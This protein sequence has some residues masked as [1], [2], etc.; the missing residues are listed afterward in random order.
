MPQ[1]GTE[2]VEVTTRPHP[3]HDD[4]SPQKKID[5]F[6]AKGF[7]GSQ[8]R[9]VPAVGAEGGNLSDHEIILVDVTW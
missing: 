4:A 2:S 7:V 9:V 3:W 6:F 1:G 8:P 5:W